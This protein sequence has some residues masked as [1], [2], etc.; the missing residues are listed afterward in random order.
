[1]PDTKPNAH[2]VITSTEPTKL[3]RT[4]VCTGCDTEATDTFVPVPGGLLR[5]SPPHSPYCRQDEFV[6]L[7]AESFLRSLGAP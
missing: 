7:N 1:M 4:Q 6:P 2:W 3:T 5:S